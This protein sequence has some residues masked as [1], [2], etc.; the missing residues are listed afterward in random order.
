MLR[1]QPVSPVEYLTT[2]VYELLDA[3]DDTLRLA[4]G[5]APDP[6]WA[7]HADYLR[8]LQRVGRAA[9]AEVAAAQPHDGSPWR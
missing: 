2:L 1:A 4:S 6:L 7:A 8:G 3:H 9:L 5:L